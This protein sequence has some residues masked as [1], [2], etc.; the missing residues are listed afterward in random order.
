MGAENAANTG[1][2]ELCIVTE[3][4]KTQSW[5]KIKHARKLKDLDE[6]HGD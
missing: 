6:K 5:R 3:D 2:D 1:P 4:A